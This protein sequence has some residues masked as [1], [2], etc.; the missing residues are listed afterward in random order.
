MNFMLNRTRV[1]QVEAGADE[2]ILQ[3]LRRQGLTGTK[4]GCASGDCGACT[5]LLG[6]RDRS[7]DVH[8]SPVNACIALLGGVEGKHL[9]TV[10]GLERDGR[11]HPVQKAMVEHHGSQCGFCTPGFVMSLAGLVE[12]QGGTRSG[13]VE[14]SSLAQMVSTAISGNLCRCTG[15]RP[16]IDAGISALSQGGARILSDEEVRTFLDQT[17]SGKEE[18]LQHYYR[19]GTLEDLD[20]LVGTHGRACIVAGGTDLS[21][22][23]T[24]R[25]ER[26]TPMI[27][28]REVAALGKITM[29]AGQIAI[30]AAVTLE[31]LERELAGLSGP[32]V[33]LLHRFGSPQ[34]RHTGT[35]GGNIGNASPI[36]DLPPALMSWDA[37]IELRQASGTRRHL[38]LEDFYTGYRETV[39]GDDEYILG[40]LVPLASVHRFHRFYKHSKRIEDDISSVM[41]AFSFARV[42]EEITVAR[43]AYGGMAAVPVRLP[44]VEDVLEGNP[45]TDENIGKACEQLKDRLE[46][47]SDVRASAG[48]RLAMAAEMLER[49][50]LELRGESLPRIDE[51]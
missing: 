11:L 3:W 26:R 36:A 38:P 51:L 28:L 9:V 10:E 1:S 41:G 20:R 45:P 47:I 29:D 14:A 19:P 49:A 16:I 25:W 12:S 31:N 32:L 27:D 13:S 7:G 35:V 42:G 39:L 15:Y 17:G 8:Y 2:T 44:D 5:V 43:I 23:M 18:P 6:E 34:I 33:Q 4:E 46:P 30:G 40:I 48:F 37:R 22:A 24:Q 50:L 21:L